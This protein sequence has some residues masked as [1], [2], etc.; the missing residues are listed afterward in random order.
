MLVSSK[1]LCNTMEWKKRLF[2]IKISI[3]L[4][5]F[6]TSTQGHSE[7]HLGF[8]AFS[9]KRDSQ[10]K[11]FFKLLLLTSLYL[12]LICKKFTVWFPNRDAEPLVWIFCRWCLV[13]GKNLSLSGIS[14]Q[15]AQWIHHCSTFL[16]PV[17][18]WPL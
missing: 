6:S 16:S 13:E 14:Q 11:I 3:F 7:R 17:T 18:T 2:S 4:V 8:P 1:H 15:W 5:P 9:F 10:N 12:A